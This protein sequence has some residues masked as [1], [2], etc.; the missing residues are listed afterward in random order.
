[1]TAVRTNAMRHFDLQES[2]FCFVFF[3]H[4]FR[5]EEETVRLCSLVSGNLYHTTEPIQGST[6]LHKDTDLR[7]AEKQVKRL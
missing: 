5:Q 2:L 6:V 1:M 7:S 4:S 3:F